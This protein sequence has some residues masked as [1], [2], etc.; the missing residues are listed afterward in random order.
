[1]KVAWL[2]VAPVKGL[3]IE[4]RQRIELGPSGVEDDRLFCLVEETG[5][6][7][8]GKRLAQLSTI[9]P[10][11]DTKT[12]HLELRM[13]NGSAVKGTVAVAEPITVTVYGHAGP[14][15]VVSG[16]WADA[17][18]DEVGRPVRVVRFDGP[19]Q[20]HDRADDSAGATLLSTGSLERLQQEAGAA[21]PVDPRRFRMLI[22]VAGAGAHEEDSWIGRRVRVGE[23]VVV[24]AGNVGR[25]V[26]TTRDPDTAEPTL[27][28]L[29]LLARYRRNIGTTEELAFGVWAHIERPGVVRIGDPVE[30]EP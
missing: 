10:R 1:M 18:S 19:G 8:N 25:C 6:L 15:H 23:A 29:E 26:V 7:L 17:L 22:G 3:R 21:E 16:P 4:E 9:V 13:P 5:R 14:G 24:P 20:G 28:T 11:Y 12:G 30:V 27:D 2:H